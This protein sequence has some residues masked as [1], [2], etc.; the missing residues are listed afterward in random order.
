MIG[1]YVHHQGRGHLSRL[2]AVAAHLNTPVVGLSSLARPVGWDGDWVQLRR[3][4]RR[5]EVELAAGTPSPDS[6][7]DSATASV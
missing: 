1:Y 2:Q 4:E 3:D 7:A 5:L 6:T